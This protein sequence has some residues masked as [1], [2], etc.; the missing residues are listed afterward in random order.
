MDLDFNS[1][2]DLD[3][4]LDVVAGPPR[5]D[6]NL[7]QHLAVVIRPPRIDVDLENARLDSSLDL[8]IAI[9]THMTQSAAE[10]GSIAP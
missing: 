1:C 2:L 9:S 3:S 10:R 4:S 6:L 5:I 8:D 7:E